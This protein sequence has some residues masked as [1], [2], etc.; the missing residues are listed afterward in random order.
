MVFESIIGLDT[1]WP[2]DVY[3][4]I[5]KQSN[6]AL[7]QICTSKYIFLF[8]LYYLS[9]IPNQL[10]ATLRNSQYIKI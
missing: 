4:F 5:Q 1:E 6:V 10:V 8:Q 7:I 2:S 3:N 9:K